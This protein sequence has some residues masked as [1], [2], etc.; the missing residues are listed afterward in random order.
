MMKLHETAHL[1]SAYSETPATPFSK[2]IT[3]HLANV[4]IGI[5]AEQYIHQQENSLHSKSRSASIAHRFKGA[6]S[7][8][9]KTVKSPAKYAEMLSY[10]LSHL[11]E[12]VKNA[13]GFPVSYWIH[14]QVILEAKRLLY[15][16]DLDI[17]EIAFKLGYDDHTYFS[18]LFS[19][20]VR[21]SPST[22]RHK[23]HE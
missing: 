23:F 11:N 3:L 20:M 17:K 4:F 21:M 16:T 10:S 7:D 9:F 8:N 14:Q 13:T 6:L 22:F 1:L 12:S 18:R 2:D 5:I 15:Y 19:K